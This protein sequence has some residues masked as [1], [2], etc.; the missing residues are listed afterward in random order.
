[1]ALE[2]AAAVVGRHLWVVEERRVYLVVAVEEHCY[3]LVVVEVVEECI[4][5]SEI[6]VV[7]LIS[8]V[9]VVGRHRHEICPDLE[10]EGERG[11][12]WVVEGEQLICALR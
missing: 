10:A 8:V 6:Q 1:M 11:R 2:E 9:V 7:A 3:V 12:D 5:L 4:G